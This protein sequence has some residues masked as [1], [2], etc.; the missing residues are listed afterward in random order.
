MPRIY[1]SIMVHCLSIDPKFKP[2]KHKRRAFNAKRYMVINSEVNKHLKAS[3]IRESQYLEWIA[4]VVLVK[5]VNRSWRVCVDLTDLNR[6]CPKDSFLF[7][8]IDQLVD[9]TTRYELMSFMDAYS[10]YNQIR[11]H[12]SNQEHTSFLIDQGLFFYNVMPFGLKN[13]DATYQRMVNKMFKE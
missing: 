4:N 1:P 11:M 8:R 10:C 2:V 3:F 6:A 13:A 12:E 9:A 7:P 5:K